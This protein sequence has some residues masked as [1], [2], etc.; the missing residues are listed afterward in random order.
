[1]KIGYIASHIYL[2]TFEINEVA[3]LLRQHPG[4]RIY[5]FYR[6]RG[7]RLQSRRISEVGED[8]VSWTYAS[9]LKGLRV[10][11]RHPLGFLKGAAALSL[12]SIANPVYWIKNLLTFFVALPI[13]HDAERQGVT[14]LH[15]N[16]GSSPATIA[17]LGRKALG[18]GMSVTYHAFDIYSNAFTSRDPLKA[19]KLRDADLVVAV[20]DDGRRHLQRLVPDVGD[21]KF[22]VI[23]VCV[24]FEPAAKVE[25]LPEPP[26]LVA[27]GNL[28]PKKGFDVLVRA[29]GML[30]RRGVQVRLRILGEGEQR[31]YLEALIREQGLRD[32]VELRGYFQHQ[33]LA[34]HLAPAAA[35]VV[36]S[37]VTSAGQRDGIPTVVVEAW[38]SRTPV[39]ASLVGGMAEVIKRDE[40]GLVFPAGDPEALAETLMRLLSAPELGSALAGQGHRV[41]GELFSPSRNVSMLLDEINN[42][43]L[44]P[45]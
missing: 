26:L 5:S 10:I 4:A 30:K 23:R 42:H 44:R 1:M 20:H 38:L 22:R 27:A 37:L 45:A 17:W 25:P 16:F 12:Y 34:E 40:T 7:S 15:A 28:V 9:V 3:E 41:A 6:P 24:A 14:H 29:V 21:D 19:R 18:M 43:S 31:P 39:V 8:V 33:D 32:R 13:L 35:F 36:P 2:H 11:G